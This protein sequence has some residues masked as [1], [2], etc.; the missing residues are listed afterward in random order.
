MNSSASG[1][2]LIGVF[3]RKSIGPWQR[4][5]AVTITTWPMLGL[6]QIID[7]HQ[8]GTPAVV[9][10]PSWVSFCP[11]F[12]MPYFGMLFATWLLPVAIRD[13]RRF[14]ACLIAD[15]IAYL[16]IMPC[17]L[18]FPTTLSRPPLPVEWWAAPYLV[19]V[20]LD[21]PNNVFPCAHSFGPLVAAWFVVQEHPNWRWPLLGMLALGLSSIALA[22]QHRP[23]DILLGI[24]AAGVGIAVG[25]YI[26]THQDILILK[27][28]S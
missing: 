14:R 17:W 18:V 15:V 10:M 20:N 13:A 16:L 3:N 19:L 4:L 22:W 26:S 27:L 24:L 21:P 9:S 1:Q 7:R 6:Y 28:R 12:V 11:A 5:L 25:K 23:I 8:F 2:N